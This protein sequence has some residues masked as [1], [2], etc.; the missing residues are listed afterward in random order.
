MDENERNGGSRFN[1][2]FYVRSDFFIRFWD[3]VP[4]FTKRIVLNLGRCFPFNIS[5]RLANS[6][7]YQV[8][9][10]L[11]HYKTDS[12]QLTQAHLRI[13]SVFKTCVGTYPLSTHVPTYVIIYF[14]TTIFKLLLFFD[15]IVKFVLK[16]MSSQFI[17]FEFISTFFVTQKVKIESLFPKVWAKF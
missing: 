6:L 3:R 4:Q 5:Y 10:T 13:L 7:T 12:N 15:S 14:R 17:S 1:R 11:Q 16:L 9:E 8:R 2:D